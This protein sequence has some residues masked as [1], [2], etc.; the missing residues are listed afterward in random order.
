LSYFA[1]KNTSAEMEEAWEVH[2]KGGSVGKQRKGEKGSVGRGKSVSGN[3]KT[4]AG[5]H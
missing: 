2:R 3:E 4:T 1:A 5:R